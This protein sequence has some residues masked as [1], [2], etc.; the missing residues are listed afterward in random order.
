VPAG[1]AAPIGGP[2]RLDVTGRG[3]DTSSRAAGRHHADHGADDH[4]HHHNYDD[5][6]YDADD[7]DDTE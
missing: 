3:A 4:H 7:H 5:H 1:G 2:G 6:D